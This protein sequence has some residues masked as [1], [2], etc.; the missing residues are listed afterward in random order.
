MEGESND[1]VGTRVSRYVQVWS[2][3]TSNLD[4]NLGS[5]SP[6][7][8]LLETLSFLRLQRTEDIHMYLPHASMYALSGMYCTTQI[9]HVQ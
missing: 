6:Q 3:L 2:T 1:L 5:A 8:A 7:N 4:R 9:M